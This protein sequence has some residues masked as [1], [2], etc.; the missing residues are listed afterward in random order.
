MCRHEVSH[1]VVILKMRHTLENHRTNLCYKFTLK[2]INQP[3]NNGI[4]KILRV[5]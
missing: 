4:N 1:A 2:T 3:K 5:N